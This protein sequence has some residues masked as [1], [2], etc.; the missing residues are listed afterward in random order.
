MGMV[1]DGTVSGDGEGWDGVEWGV[2]EVRA[3]ERYVYVGAE[4]SIVHVERKTTHTHM[5]T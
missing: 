3:K 1:R 2:E 5:Y 4:G